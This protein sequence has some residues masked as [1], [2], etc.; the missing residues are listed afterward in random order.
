MPFLK[1]A[2]R[3]TFEVLLKLKKL[4][5]KP[6]YSTNNKVRT[7]S[8]RRRVGEFSKEVKDYQKHL[9]VWD[10]IKKRRAALKRH[11]P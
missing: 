1:H 2:N 7:R 9:S 6:L 10:K 4:L 11:E 5:M 8:Y 3:F